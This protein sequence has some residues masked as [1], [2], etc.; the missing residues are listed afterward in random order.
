VRMRGRIG[1]AS[2]PHDRDGANS[3][4]S[5]CIFFFVYGSVSFYRKMYTTKDESYSLYRSTFDSFTR[6]MKCSQAFIGLRNS[7]VSC[8]TKIH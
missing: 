4:R 6:T 8:L 3:P 7:L 1:S 5:D 2:S